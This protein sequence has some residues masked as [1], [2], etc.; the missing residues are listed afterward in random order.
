[1]RAAVGRGKFDNPPVETG[2][3]REV[4]PARM[5]IRHTRQND[6]VVGGRS[7]GG[8]VQLLGAVGQCQLRVG[9][10][11]RLFHRGPQMDD[12]TVR[13]A[14]PEQ[15]EADAN[16]RLRVV[17]GDREHDSKLKEC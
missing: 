17:R 8:P 4:G 13:I 7:L 14:V 16:M 12:S 10:H 5:E 11:W 9:K 1:M 3:C 2:S 15:D 6:W